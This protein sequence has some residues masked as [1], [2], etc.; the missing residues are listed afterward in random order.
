M[1]DLYSSGTIS[2]W[3]DGAGRRKAK[4]KNDTAKICKA[5]SKYKPGTKRYVRCLNKACE[6]N[7][8]LVASAVRSFINNR[9]SITWR[10]NHVEDL[11]QQG[12]FGLRRAVEKFNPDR[13]YTFSTYAMPWIRQAIGRYHTNKASAVYIPEGVTQQIFYI[14]RHGKKKV[15]KSGLATSDRLLAAARCAMHPVRLDAPYGDNLAPLHESIPH[16]TPEPSYSGDEPNWATEML[17]EAID[18]AGL[19][20]LEADLI[21]SY[22]HAGRIPSAARHCGLSEHKARPIIRKAIEKIKTAHQS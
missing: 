8:L 10:D 20:E 3:L 13:G 7:L 16:V 6:I 14:A 21:R 1:V 5:M 4:D 17:G 18:V 22:A 15:N 12:Y 9:A 11:L 2:V 19:S